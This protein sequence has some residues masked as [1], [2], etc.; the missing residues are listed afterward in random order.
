[1]ME[2]GASLAESLLFGGGVAGGLAGIGA[3]LAPV[4]AAAGINYGATQLAKVFTQED[5]A[6]H[7]EFD[8]ANA[9]VGSAVGDMFG[10]GTNGDGVKEPDY[11]A[12]TEEGW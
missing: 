1:M 5:D 11:T 3:I 10:A 8:K 2:G 12:F 7:S 9:A 4:L 6:G